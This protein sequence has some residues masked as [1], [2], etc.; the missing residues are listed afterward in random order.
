MAAAADEAAT[1]WLVITSLSREKIQKIDRL[2]ASEDSRSRL[3]GGGR[4]TRSS[5]GTLTVTVGTNGAAA[6]G[7]GAVV[8]G[9]ADLTGLTTADVGSGVVASRTADGLS[10]RAGGTGRLTSEKSGSGVGGH[11]SGGRSQDKDSGELHNCD[12]FVVGRVKEWCV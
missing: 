1:R 11:G 12:W 4:N 5:G 6:V 2:T 9:S 8:A 7:A 10:V 3:D